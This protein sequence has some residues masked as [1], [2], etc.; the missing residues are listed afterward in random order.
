MIDFLIAHAQ[1]QLPSS[2]AAS[3]GQTAGNQIA[4]GGMVFWI[5]LVLGVPFAFWLVEVLV[6][7]LTSIPSRRT[8]AETPA[9]RAVALHERFKKIEKEAGIHTNVK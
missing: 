7:M 3:I 2:T 8:K 5:A 4:Q 1:I 9:G 6:D